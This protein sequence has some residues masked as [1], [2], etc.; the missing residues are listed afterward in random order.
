MSKLKLL[1]VTSDG[2]KTGA[3]TQVRLLASGLKSVYEIACCCPDGWLKIE[4]EKS[5]ISTYLWPTGDFYAQKKALSNFFWQ[6]NPQLI[7]CHGVRAGIIGRLASRPSTSKVVYTEHLWTEN[8]QLKNP[9]RQWLQLFFMRR[10]ASG[11]DWIVAVSEAVERF[12]I[13]KH[14]VKRN[15]VSVIYGA[16]EPVPPATPSRA[17]TVGTLGRLTW[18]KDIPTLLK[19]VAYIKERQP[20]LICRIGGEGREKIK[21]QRLATALGIAK[22]CHWQGE[23][24]DSAGFYH[25]L[26]VYVQSSI[27]ESF[28]LAAAE[29]MSAGIP[30]VGSRVG[31]LVELITDN[32]DGLL[33][34]PGDY[35]ALGRAIDRLLSDKNLCQRLGAAGR[36]RAST[37]SIERFLAEHRKLYNTLTNTNE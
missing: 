37:F 21:Y 11:G 13:T 27:S 10:A 5:G 12:L 36:Q 17:P 16:V 30:V 14:L 4:L 1:F 33:F 7:H 18:V 2:S 28:G 20:N 19:A 26:S 15:R 22:R 31:G 32:K 9:L 8:F 23:V 6:A 35:K 24:S 34:P 29:A 25:D 3:P